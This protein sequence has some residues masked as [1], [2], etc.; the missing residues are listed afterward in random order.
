MHIFQHTLSVYKPSQP[1]RLYPLSICTSLEY[2]KAAYPLHLLS[3]STPFGLTQLLILH[4]KRAYELK[5]FS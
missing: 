5:V 4:I 3:V 2:T 1:F